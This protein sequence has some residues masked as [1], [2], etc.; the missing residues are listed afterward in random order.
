MGIL[1][2][3]YVVNFIDR[4]SQL[5]DTESHTH[6]RV[7]TFW[8]RNRAIGQSHSRATNL[9]QQARALRT[10]WGCCGVQLKVFQELEGL[11]LVARPSTRNKSHSMLVNHGRQR[12]FVD[13]FLV[14]MDGF[15]A[16]VE[17]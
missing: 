2:S 8:A 17:E 12:C 7:S 9:V 4:V 5:R 13:D 10:G 3:N 16:E 14:P 6:L 15:I 1:P 11:A